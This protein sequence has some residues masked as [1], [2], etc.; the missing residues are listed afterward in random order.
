MNELPLSKFA[1]FNK[2][3]A[4][5]QWEIHNKLKDLNV[6]CSNCIYLG[7]SFQPDTESNCDYYVCNI[8]AT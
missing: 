6:E 1:P 8:L 7:E 4:L 5:F 2:Q 3:E